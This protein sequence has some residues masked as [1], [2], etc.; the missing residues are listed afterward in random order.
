MTV[1]SFV[2]IFE[3]LGLTRADAGIEIPPFQRDYAQGR[4]EPLVD[5]IRE[6]F[7]THLC[8]ALSPEAEPVS[9]A[10]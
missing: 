1:T 10:R 4:S 6:E 8:G 3:N 5:A 2:G 7:L 9:L